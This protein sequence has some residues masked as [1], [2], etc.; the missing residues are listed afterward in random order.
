MKRRDFL[1]STGAVTGGMLAGLRTM[2]A[3]NDDA[4]AGP[5][6]NILFILVDE[7]RYPTVFPQG[8][9][10]AGQ[11]LARFMPNLHKLWQAG[12]KF[13]NYYTA[14]NACTP[15]RGTLITGLY[16]QQNWLITTILSKPNPNPALA[17]LQPAL[18]HHFPTYGKLLR[19]AG[20]STPYF[21]KWHVSIPLQTSPF[22]WQ[23]TGLDNYGF[24]YYT[25]PDPTGSNLQGAYGDD[26][27]QN[28]GPGQMYLSDVDTTNAAVDFLQKRIPNEKPW[29]LTVSLINPHDREFF[30]AGTEFKTVSNLFEDEAP[31][32]GN[33][34]PLTNYADKSLVPWEDNALRAPAS[35]GYP[36]VPPNW[37]SSDRLK[38]QGKPNTQLFIK[39]FQQLVWGGVTDDPART[40]PADRTVDPYP[41]EDL[42]FGV[43]KM[44][45][46]YWQRGLDSY[47]QIMGV[48]DVQI[49]RVLDALNSLPSSI[50]ENTV[51]VFTS[52]HGE[53]AGAHGL[54]QGKLG[55]VYEE[56]W[57]IPLIVFDPSQRFTADVDAIRTGLAS[58][59]DLLPLLVSIGNNG[60]RSWMQGYL[61][62]IYGRRL[63]MISMLRSAAAPGRPYVLYATDEIAPKFFNFNQCPTHVLGIRTPDSKLGVYADWFPA[64]SAINRRKTQLEFYDYSTSSGQLELDN[65]AQ[66]D[67][68]VEKMYHH[69]LNHVIPQE[70]Q[71]LLPPPLVRE[72]EKSKLAHL[73]YRAFID[74]LPLDVFR[75]K[76]Q[77][78]TNILGYGA[79]F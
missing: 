51:V 20:Y 10:D 49:G 13:G 24:D 62:D 37:E 59:V 23:P 68:R 14:A 7:L 77:G 12:V 36:A 38:E 19:A 72:Q 53:Y 58:S 76:Q 52:D 9:S 6:P 63:D 65:A 17:A 28:P 73:A 31:A 46:T 32:N 39:E 34:Q 54:L 40:T 42:G 29:C 60:T 48:V 66:S 33:L 5:Q 74:N 18:N 22:P 15:A 67:P 25:Y 3:S 75:A 44:E 45:Y 8:I 1:K 64:T 57:R 69:L 79:D 71:A 4:V 43:A 61:A 55:T 35:Y 11:F 26:F 21:G 70:L 50:V 47:T 16:S 27:I 78:L 2:K 41:A 56:A 30:P